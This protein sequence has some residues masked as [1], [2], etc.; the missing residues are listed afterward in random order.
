MKGPRVEAD[1][2]LVVDKPAGPTSHDVVQVARR[3]FGPRVGHTGTLD[4]LASG[5]LPLVLGRA[6]RLAQFLTGD[7]KTYE[8]TIV[9]G[10]D[11]DTYDA[12]GATVRATGLVPDAAVV[13][14]AVA[15]LPGRQRQTPPV[16]SAKKIGGE[17]AHRLA[18]RDA[19]V[20]P[21]PADVEIH[22]ATLTGYSG[23]ELQLRLHV[24]AGF[25]VRT[26]AHDLG[27]R[28]GTGAHLGAL[29]RTAAGPF[30]LADAVAWP[31]LV[32]GDAA[33]AAAVI[34]PSG[35]LQHLPEARLDA[36]GAVWVR[37]GRRVTATVTGPAGS[38]PVRLIDPA[39]RLL[40]LATIVGLVEPRAVVLQ[41]SVVLGY[42]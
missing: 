27:Q 4:P 23:G 26:L 39:G 32:A 13:A 17:A 11:T 14:D 31:S 28:L 15:R 40:G 34:P 7:A 6:T 35:L 10:R 24:S 29:R 19:P 1:G 8:A 41:P 30:T 42:D 22:A 33:L 38:G 12:A 25:Y 21:P 20:V 3:T 36:Q 37:H 16:Y 2:V 18:R 5:V 9:F